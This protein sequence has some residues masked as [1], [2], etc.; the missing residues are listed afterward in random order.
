MLKKRLIPIVLFNDFSLV[1]TI[2]FGETRI[3]G[4]PVQTVRVYNAREVDELVFLDIGAPREHKLISF[5]LV[6]EIS[7]ECFMPLTVGGGISSVEQMRKL[8]QIGADKI[9]INTFAFKNPQLITAA[10][11]KFGSQAIVVSVDAKKVNNSYEVFIEGGTQPTRVDLVDWIKKIENCGAGEIL[12]NSI[13]RDGK[14]TGYDI[15]LIKITT[16]TVSIPV[17]SAGGA[18]KPQDFVTAI[19]D[20]KSDAVAAASIFHYTQHT[21][22]SIKAFMSNEGI[23]V[24]I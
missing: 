9:S 7:E 3:L 15:D 2:Q 18:G 6:S 17:I 16:G 24:R 23:P 13:D 11:Q 4:N 8:L 1:K 19:I 21:P 22:K 14:M 12:L 20:G 5:Q 10:A